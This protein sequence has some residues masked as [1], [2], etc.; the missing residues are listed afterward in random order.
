[1]IVGGSGIVLCVLA[2][3]AFRYVEGYARRGGMLAQ[4]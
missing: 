2:V 3:V 4:Y 1:M